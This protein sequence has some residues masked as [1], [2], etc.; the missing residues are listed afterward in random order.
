MAN[1]LL[2][3]QEVA[4]SSPVG[5]QKVCNQ[6]RETNWIAAIKWWILVADI[7]TMV[8]DS[9]QAYHLPHEQN[10][11]D[12]PWPSWSIKPR[13]VSFRVYK[14]GNISSTLHLGHS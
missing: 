14:Q 4:C 5:G 6:C 7:R 13:P 10:L 1:A 3:V 12:R 2:L 9:L 8:V 11:S